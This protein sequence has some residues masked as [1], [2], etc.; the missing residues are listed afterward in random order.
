MIRAMNFLYKLRGTLSSTSSQ[1]M[2]KPA[3]ISK[4][5]GSL[6]FEHSDYMNDLAESDDPNETVDPIW[7]FGYMFHETTDKDVEDNV[8]LLERIVPEE[9]END[10]SKKKTCQQRLTPLTTATINLVN[11]HFINSIPFYSIFCINNQ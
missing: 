8:I 7:I 3:L 5:S 6:W 1:K 11:I 10:A 4:K 9:D 2:P